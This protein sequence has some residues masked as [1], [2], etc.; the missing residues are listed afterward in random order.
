MES[1]KMKLTVESL[2]KIIKE[3][4]EEETRK[5]CEAA[6]HRGEY[7]SFCYMLSD[8]TA[9]SKGKIKAIKN[10]PTEKTVTVSK[11]DNIKRKG[12]TIM[13][14]IDKEELIDIQ[15]KEL[16]RVVRD[17][18]TASWLRTALIDHVKHLDEDALRALMSHS[19]AVQR[20][21]DTVTK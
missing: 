11:P 20:M 17:P 6:Q 13:E 5:E 14:L 16:T 1:K 10:K 8:K 21:I 2:K 9:S 3:V 19:G 15:M 18:E 12:K 7:R 4:L